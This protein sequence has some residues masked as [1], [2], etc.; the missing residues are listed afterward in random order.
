[1]EVK[2]AEAE[3]IPGRRG[4]SWLTVIGRRK[5]I[6]GGTLYILKTSDMTLC[7]WYLDRAR[8]ENINRPC[9][10]AVEQEGLRTTNEHFYLSS[11]ACFECHGMSCNLKYLATRE[12]GLLGHDSRQNC[13]FQKYETPRETVQQTTNLSL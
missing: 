1:V 4:L 6:C 12:L 9:S 7:D 13:F 10:I 2:E 11:T 3:H 8:I 5:K